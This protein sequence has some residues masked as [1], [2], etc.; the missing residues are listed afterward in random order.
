MAR[1]RSV[2]PEFWIDEKVVEMGLAS[3]LLF[4]GLWNFADDQGYIDD[5]PRRIK[6]QVFPGDDFDVEPLLDELVAAGLLVRYDSPVGPVLHVRNWDKHQKVDRASTPRFETSTLV[7][8]TTPP[9]QRVSPQVSATREDTSSPI[10]P[11]LP[12]LDAEG[13]GSGSGRDL[14][15]DL[16]LEGI[17]RSASR[18]GAREPPRLSVTQ[19]SK[20]ITNAYSAIEPLCKWPAINAIVIRALKAEKWS[21]DEVR[22]ALLR[23]A[24]EGRSVTVD[25]LRVELAGLPPPSRNG[26]VEV[27]G[28]HLTAQT[29]Q[30][31]T[32]DRQRLAAMDQQRL[33]I[34]GPSP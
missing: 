22:D 34:E 27:N 5:K 30:R 2:K 3:R 12:S 14:D 29:A 20:E 1:I 33:A 25:T 11:S 28:Y 18:S 4:I 10:E 26:L 21:D 24:A 8:R 7:V 15:L 19:R 9:V 16:D 23:L 6:M 31:M 17:A 13:K 32:T